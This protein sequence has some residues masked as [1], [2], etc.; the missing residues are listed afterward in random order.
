VQ[1][2]QALLVPVLPPEQAR[3]RIKPEYRP[4]LDRFGMASLL[5]VPL[6]AHGRILGTLGVSRDRPG[7][8][9]GPDDQALLQD[10]ADRAGL[11]IEN[12]R[13]YAAA[14]AA[15]EEAEQANRAKSE[16]L[17]SM[18]HELRTPLNAIIGFTGTLLMKLPGPLNADQQKQLTT[19]QSSARHLLALINDLLDLARIEAGRLD[20]RLEPVVCQD[21]IGEVAASLRPL[22]EQ[23]GLRFSLVAP[24]EPVVL[25]T[26]RRALSQIVINLVSNAIKFTEHGEVTI[27]VAREHVTAEDRGSKIEDS[28]V[29]VDDGRSSIFDPR[30]SD[31]TASD[32]HRTSAVVFRV[33]DTGSG[34]RPEDQERL[35]EAFARGAAAPR[36]SEGAGLGLHLSQKLAALLGARIEFQSVYGQGSTFALVLSER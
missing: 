20:L 23:K 25:R 18:S 16:F 31:T 11:A 2:G 35:F 3:A 17:S 33:S 21:V 27:E 26:D 30:S 5:L 32:G 34:I 24:A 10:L 9:Y 15:R 36:P 29:G 19:V 6:R 22:A 12:A 7:R 14:R 28:T 1:T 4:W 8:P 13:L